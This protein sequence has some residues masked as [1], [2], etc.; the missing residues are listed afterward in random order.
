[1]FGIADVA[2]PG[3]LVA[4]LALLARALSVSLAGDHCVAATVAPDAAAG[5]KISIMAES[6]PNTAKQKAKAPVPSTS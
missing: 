6:E 5:W 2:A 1:M 3:K 4:F